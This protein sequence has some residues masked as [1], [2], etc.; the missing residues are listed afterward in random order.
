MCQ[1]VGPFVELAIAQT[2]FAVDHCQ[3]LRRALGLRFEHPMNGLFVRI[4]Q[5]RIVELHQQLLTLGSRQDRQT[6]EGSVR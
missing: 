4:F 3:R 5:R 1:A 6:V 2:L